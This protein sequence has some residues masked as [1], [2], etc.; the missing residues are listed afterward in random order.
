MA[1]NIRDEAAL[2]HSATILEV[3]ALKLLQSTRPSGLTYGVDF[4]T[5]SH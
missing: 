4:F 1:I 5:P 3:S 2:E